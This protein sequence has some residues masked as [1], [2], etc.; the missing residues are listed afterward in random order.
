MHLNDGSVYSELYFNIDVNSYNKIINVTFCIE[1]LLLFFDF[2]NYPKFYSSSE[3]SRKSFNIFKQKN[4]H[5]IK[6]IQSYI[7]GIKLTPRLHGLF[8]HIL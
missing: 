5:F 7:I 4:K 3:A 2:S 1:S 6:T 8:R